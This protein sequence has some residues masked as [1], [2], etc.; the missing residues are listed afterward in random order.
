MRGGQSSTEVF[1]ASPD[2]ALQRCLVPDFLGEDLFLA[3][4]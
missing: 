1:P 4:R 3:D 2:P